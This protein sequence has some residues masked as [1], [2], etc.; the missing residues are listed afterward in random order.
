[1]REPSVPHVAPRVICLVLGIFILMVTRPVLSSQSRKARPIAFQKWVKNFNG[2]RD[3]CKHL[4]N[5]K[6]VLGA[7]Q[8]ED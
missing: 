8:V 7:K 2:S 1:M 3:T 5:F 4:T 6:Q